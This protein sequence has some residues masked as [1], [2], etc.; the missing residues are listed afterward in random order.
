M[1]FLTNKVFAPPFTSKVARLVVR[2][3]RA[4]QL[5]TAFEKARCTRVRKNGVIN[6]KTCK[7]F[8]VYFEPMRFF[9]HA[10]A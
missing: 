2:L 9:L 1:N 4:R 5:L 6:F 3:T 8:F 7:V 10:V